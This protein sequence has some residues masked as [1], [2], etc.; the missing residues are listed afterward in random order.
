MLVFIGILLGIISSIIMQTVLAAVLPSVAEDLGNSQLYSWVFSGYL[1][2][3]TI[4]I[5]IFAKLADL[6]GRK[7]FYLG[8]MAIFLSGTLLC[9]TSQSMEQLVIFRLLQGFGAGISS[10]AAIAMISDI[11]PVAKRG[12]ILGIMASAQVVAN[13]A[14]PLIGG[15]FAE[16]FGWQWAF[17]AALPIGVFAV[18]I[19]AVVFMEDTT[20][21]PKIKARQVD[22]MGGL[23]LGIVTVLIIQGFKVLYIHGFV[24]TLI[25]FAIAG[26]FFR[27]F[28]KQEKNHIDPVISSDLLKTKNIKVCLISTFLLGAVMYGIIVI[29]PIFANLYFGA[30]PLQGGKLLLPLALGLGIGGNLSGTLTTGVFRYSFITTAGWITTASAFCFLAV[31]SIKKLYYF[32]FL[33]ILFIVGLGLGGLFPIFLLSGQNAVAKNQRAV[34]GGLIQM[35]RNLGG[36]VGVP[37]LTGLMIL[38]SSG[39]G[40]RYNNYYVG[41]FLILTI[42]SVMGALIGL[43]LKD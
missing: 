40:I 27:L 37:L 8:G 38:P 30:A 12:K 42:V 2:I 22:F 14:G 4:T 35:S 25:N 19:V 23:L 3:S 1:I 33:G 21:G 41:L 29:L 5:P 16:S 10:P 9:G 36:A 24:H 7:R 28:V 20:H 15:Y 43:R 6:F 34:I 39:S 11:F 13:V 18:I 32:A 31:F 17:W 26:L